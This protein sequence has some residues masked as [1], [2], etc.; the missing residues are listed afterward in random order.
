MSTRHRKFMLVENILALYIIYNIC[1]I[2][3]YFSSYATYKIKHLALYQHRRKN[4][5]PHETF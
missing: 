4:T 1:T 2:A 5:S 3:L